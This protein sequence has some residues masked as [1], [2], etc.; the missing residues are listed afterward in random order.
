MKKIYLI[1]AHKT[2][3]QLERQIRALND[4]Q[5]IFYIHIDLKADLNLFKNISQIKN[6]FVI[7]ERVDCIWGDFSTIIATLNL[8]ENAIKNESEGFCILMS[9]NDYPIKSISAINSFISQNSDKVFIDIKEAENIWPTFDKR[10]KNYKIN[11]SSARGNFLLL[12]GMNKQTLSCLKKRQINF[13]QFIR[14]IFKKRKLTPEI[15]FYGGSQW[16]AMNLSEVIKMNDYINSHKNQLFNFFAYSLLPDEFF[17]HSLIMHF[18]ELGNP[19]KIEESLTYV[20]WNRQNCPLPVTFEIND[21]D[22]LLGQPS[23]KLFARK[24]DT[25]IDKQIL[26][27]IDKKL[28]IDF[29]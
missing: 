3:E 10:I 14:I 13:S 1:L 5:S 23:I 16:W 9:G 2:P 8:I 6:V 25:E 22:E 27:R 19:L 18:R 7:K 4:E 21:F 28:Y 24:F 26:D 29:P 20:N 11:L 17:F 15:K 12:K